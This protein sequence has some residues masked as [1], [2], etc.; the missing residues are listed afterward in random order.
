MAAAESPARPGVGRSD[1]PG[2]PPRPRPRVAAT[3]VAAV[4]PPQFRGSRLLSVSSGTSEPMRQRV[5]DLGLLEFEPESMSVG[6]AAEDA[7]HPLGGPP[8]P[9]DRV[10]IEPGRGPTRAGKPADR[11]PARPASRNASAPS[12]KRKS[13]G[14]GS[15]AGVSTRRSSSC[16]RKNSSARSAGDLAGL[17]TVK[18]QHH[19][20]GQPARAP[21]DDLTQGR[22]QRADDVAQSDLVRRDHVGISLDHR[23]PAGLAAGVPRQ[24]GRVEDRPLVKERRLGA[25]EILGDILPCAAIA[26]STSGKNSPAEPDRPAP[27]SWIGKI[28]RPRNRSRTGPGRIVR[29]AD[30][31]GLLQ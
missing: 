22:A 12:F 21:G 2:R 4:R 17:V 10:E 25:V 24:V 19:P 27:S 28:S 16:P 14:R 7:K 18:D 11:R 8:R 13:Q 31:A 9:F 29:S 30:Q 6:H 26:R 15:R 20:V 5:E 1:G 3:G 23:H